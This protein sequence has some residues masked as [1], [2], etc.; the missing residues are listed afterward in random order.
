MCNNEAPVP[1]TPEDS[2]FGDFVKDE[3]EA[4]DLEE[5]TEPWTNYE[6]ADNKNIFYPI[7][8]GDILNDRYLI[9]HKLGFGGG[10]TV[11]MAHDL[12]DKKDVALKVAQDAPWQIE[13]LYANV[14]T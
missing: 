1:T 3:D 13:E 14:H 5:V 12:L 4:E 8:L 7:C 11:W 10:S 6:T 2:D 9:E